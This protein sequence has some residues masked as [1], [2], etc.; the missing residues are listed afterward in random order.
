MK[1]E[2]NFGSVV[3][4]ILVVVL[5]IRREE[6]LQMRLADGNHVIQQFATAAADPAL[7]HTVLAKDNPLQ[8]AQP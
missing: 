3:G 1:L 6:P 4:P 8:S 2:S 5:D 7:G